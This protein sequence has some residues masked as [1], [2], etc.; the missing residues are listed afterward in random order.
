MDKTL[1]DLD[2]GTLTLSFSGKFRIFH[3][4]SNFPRNIEF[5][6]FRKPKW[7]ISSIQQFIVALVN[8]FTLEYQIK[9]PMPLTNLDQNS[10]GTEIFSTQI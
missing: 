2:L 6:G 4:I 5:S 8:H 9:V 1:Q 3:G 7:D 10:C